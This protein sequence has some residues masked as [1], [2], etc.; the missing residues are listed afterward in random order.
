LGR[1]P[2]PMWTMCESTR[3]SDQVSG[4]PRVGVVAP[5]SKGGQT[6]GGASLLRGPSCSAAQ[7]THGPHGVA[8][9]SSRGRLLPFSMRE[10]LSDLPRSGET[11]QDNQDQVDSGDSHIGYRHR[12]SVPGL[13]QR[14]WGEL[15]ERLS[16]CRPTGALTRGL[17][18]A[19]IGQ[20][21]EH[22]PRCGCTKPEGVQQSGARTPVLCFQRRNAPGVSCSHDANPCRGI[23]ARVWA[24]E[25]A[26]GTEG[27]SYSF[28]H[29]ALLSVG[30]LERHST[31]PWWRRSASHSRRDADETALPG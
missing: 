21:R 26:P 4:R 22:M 28:F 1:V 31:I 25:A 3:T 13:A 27:A 10:A 29:H 11:Q 12:G 30:V 6:G 8:R 16:P 7:R 14:D 2:G 19:T 20:C 15:G 18:C 5:S 23:R 9:S 24:D 17:I